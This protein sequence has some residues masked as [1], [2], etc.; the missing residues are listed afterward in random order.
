MSYVGN[1]MEKRNQ[2]GESLRSERITANWSRM[3]RNGSFSRVTE[4]T[5]RETD[6]ESPGFMEKV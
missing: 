1:R 3:K 2:S 4:D 6:A 5:E